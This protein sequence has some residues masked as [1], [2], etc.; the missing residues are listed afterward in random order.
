MEIQR[1]TIIIDVKTRNILRNIGRKEQTY[2]DII[3]ELIEDNKKGLKS[4]ILNASGRI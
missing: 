1:T 2:D 3:N 4:E